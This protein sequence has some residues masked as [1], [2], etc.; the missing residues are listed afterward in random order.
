MS[1]LGKVSLTVAVGLI[2]C[3]PVW[4]NRAVVVSIFELAV[5]LMN[6]SALMSPLNGSP[7][8]IR[9]VEPSPIVHRTSC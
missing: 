1:K 4:A 9:K 6:S 8:Q 7:V 2:A 3:V 5:P